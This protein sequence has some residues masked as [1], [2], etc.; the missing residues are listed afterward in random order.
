MAIFGKTTTV[1]I[2]GSS[3]T[4][5][6]ATSGAYNP[7]VVNTGNATLYLSTVSPANSTNSFGLASGAQLTVEGAD[8]TIYALGTAGQTAEVGLAT[9]VAV[10]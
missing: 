1:A 3:Q 7:T 9:L 10:D 5:H 6:T 2:T 4:L 8:V